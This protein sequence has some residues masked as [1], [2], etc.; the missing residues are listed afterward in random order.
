MTIQL[1]ATIADNPSLQANLLELIAVLNKGVMDGTID[2]DD[3]AT[4][5]EDVMAGDFSKVLYPKS[6]Q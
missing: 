5:S 6:R 1:T 2:V 3:I 4:L